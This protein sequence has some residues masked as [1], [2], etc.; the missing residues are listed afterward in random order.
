MSPSIGLPIDVKCSLTGA[1]LLTRAKAALPTPEES[2][3]ST[4]ACAK[5]SP[6]PAG[7]RARFVRRGGEVDPPPE[8]EPAVRRLLALAR[9]SEHEETHEPARVDGQKKSTQAKC[10]NA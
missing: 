6:S 9:T 7:A 2:M 5:A 4:A 3:T 8:Q 10:H 1:P